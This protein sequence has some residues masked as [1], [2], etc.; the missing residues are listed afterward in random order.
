MQ[1]MPGPMVARFAAGLISSM[2]AG[3]SGNDV[4]SFFVLTSLHPLGQ[5]RTANN[6]LSR[7]VHSGG[8]IDMTP[9]RRSEPPELVQAGGAV[10]YR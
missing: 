9:S 3:P 6:G 1:A 2:F 7:K 4:S 10:L 5:W 8:V